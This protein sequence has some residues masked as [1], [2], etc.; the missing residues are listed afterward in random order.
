MLGATAQCPHRK[1]FHT[2]L[3]AQASVYQQWQARIA[4]FHWKK[5]AALAGPCTDM[6]GFHRLCATEGGRPDGLEKEIPTLFT[7]QLSREVIDSHFGFGVLN[8]PNSVRQLLA[9][10]EMRSQL[11]AP[12]VLLLETDHVF[13][14]PLPNLATPERP[15]AWDFGYMHAHRAQN[16]IIQKYWKEGDASQL[17]PVGP[18]PC[19]IHLDALEKLTQRWL[20][21]SLGLRS[22][23]EAERVMQGWVQEMWGYSIAA[24]SV[25]IKHKVMSELQT[26]ASSLTRSVPDDFASR[27]YLFHYTYGIEYTLQG[28]PQGINQ[29]GEWSLDKRH[30]GGDHPPRHLAPPPKGANAAA[31]WLLNA[32]NEASAGIAD[33]P[34][35][36]SMG[37]IGWRRTKMDAA[38]TAGSALATKVAGTHWTWGEDTRGARRLRRPRRH[39]L[40]QG[41]RPRIM[42]GRSTFLLADPN[43]FSRVALGCSRP[44]RPR[45]RAAN[46]RRHQLQRGRHAGHSVGPQGVVGP[47]QER[48]HRRGRR[49]HALRRLPLR[50]LC[51][52]QPQPA[53]RL[54][55]HAPHLHRGARR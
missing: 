3:T 50:R 20:D 55:R 16:F 36:H 39:P 14:K 41:H 34:H 24:A 32:W 29:I 44:C 12:Y 30:Y 17:D 33:W 26:E 46:T 53:L 49:H 43:P 18:S 19:L 23:S 6:V 27:H 52:R 37:T 28:E 42:A 15:V 7:T 4:Y 45:L 8:R 13:M 22:N 40:T 54:E 48:E 21:F 10:S 25:G 38:Q 2:L 11:V 35:S 31:I 51:Q 1:P 47:D 5:Q 9:S